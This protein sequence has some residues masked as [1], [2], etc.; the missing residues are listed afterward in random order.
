[1]KKNNDPIAIDVSFSE[2]AQITASINDFSI[3]YDQPVSSGGE[4]RYP[5]PF[6]H[7]LA[8]LASC[9]AYY[10]KAYCEARDIPI[11]GMELR[12]V[13]SRAEDPITYNIELKL[14][15]GFPEKER[16]GIQRAV[17]KCTV[18]KMVLNPP[19]FS[20]KLV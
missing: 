1:M 15:E 7:F 3:H 20:L 8:S 2:G 17:D 9:S 11:K 14:P 6:E 16:A 10:A 4:G 13:F 12:A 5:N 19:V 18:K